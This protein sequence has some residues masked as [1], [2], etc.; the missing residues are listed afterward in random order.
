MGKY[1][2]GTISKDY[3][4]AVQELV[5]LTMVVAKESG[6]IGDTGGSDPDILEGLL[7]EMALTKFLSDGEMQWDETEFVDCCRLAVAHTMIRDLKHEGLIDSIEDENGDEVVWITDKGK[8]ITQF[9]T[10]DHNKEDQC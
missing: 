10:G 3:P 7:C 6:I 5:D 9:I 2:I 4:E 8:Q 1:I